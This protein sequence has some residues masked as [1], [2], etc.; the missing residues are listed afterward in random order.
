MP[1]P[2]TDRLGR[3]TPDGAGLDRDAILF[4]AG[5][6]SVRPQRSWKAIAGVLTL[7]QVLTLMLLLPWSGRWQESV[8]PVPSTKRSAPWGDDSLSP[9]RNPGTLRQR[10]LE[11]E[12]KSTPPL[13]G[14]AYVPD[15]PPLHALS[16]LHSF[17][18]N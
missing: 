11:E 6:A 9:D 3:F 17:P 15:A 8:S 12:P 2:L 18:M 16:A 13:G 5:R 14:N 1:D 10:L 4:A 7:T